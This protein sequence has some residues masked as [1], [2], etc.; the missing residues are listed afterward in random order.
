M[1]VAVLVTA[2]CGK[3]SEKNGSSLEETA[4]QGTR[5]KITKETVLGKVKY[6]VKCGEKQVIQNQYES[7]TYFHGLFL[8]D[9]ATD[10]GD[11]TVTDYR[12]L[13]ATKGVAVMSADSIGYNDDGYFFGSLRDRSE[14]YFLHTGVGFYALSGYVVSG[15]FVLAK[16]YEDWGVYTTSND[17]ILGPHYKQIVMLENGG[18]TSFLIKED[19][20]WLKLNDKGEAVSQLSSSSWLN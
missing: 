9:L 1:V 4:V 7:M 14:V 2:S 19:G 8:A 13:D 20:A 18:K 3:A 12:L 10:F 15:D 6:G 11:L 16:S 17:T 5:Y